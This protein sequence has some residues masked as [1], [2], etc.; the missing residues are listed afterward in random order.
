MSENSITENEAFSWKNHKAILVAAICFFIFFLGTIAIN[1][2]TSGLVDGNTLNVSGNETSQ[3]LWF[4]QLAGFALIFLCFVFILFSFATQL[5]SL[6]HAF[7]DLNDKN[8][9]ILRTVHEGFFSLTSD[10]KIGDQIS[11]SA[12]ELFGQNFRHGDDFFS[13]IS[14]SVSDKTLKET[15]EFISL[16]SAKHVKEQ[17]IQ[18]INP[19]SKIEVN[20]KNKLGTNKK[21]YLMLNFSRVLDQKGKLRYLLVTVQDITEKLELEEKVQNERQRSQ[22]E[23]SMLVKAME[24]DPEELHSFVENAEERLLYVNDLLR[25][26]SSINDE[27][28]LRSIIDEILR[29]IHGIKGNAAALNL[30]SITGI[31]H[32]FENEL[33]SIKNSK[34][35]KI[36]LSEEL[37]SL[38][39]PLGNLL[40]GISMLK[41]IVAQGG[42]IS[43]RTVEIDSSSG[44][45][46]TTEQL[47]EQE[48][49]ATDDSIINP[50]DR[51]ILTHLI[52]DISKE[53]GNQVQLHINCDDGWQKFSNTTS[54]TL[55][56]IGIQ[57]VRNAIVHGI[58]PEKDRVT[59]KKGKVGNITIDL[60]KTD[61]KTWRLSV[62]DDGKGLYAPT[63]RK[64]LKALKWYT[65]EKLNKLS[66]KQVIM[67]IFK[68]GFS[69]ASKTS[70][71]AGRGAGLDLIMHDMRKLSS[72]HLHISST[73]GEFTEFVLT[74]LND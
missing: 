66:D 48:S 71:H 13:L 8:Q 49:P 63:I 9:D 72:A 24:A 65:D 37:L 40:A 2:Y 18:S 29:E 68:P 26:T 70:I 46:A 52:K 34:A 35:R 32:Q 42:G 64:K 54:Q 17:L 51:N 10:F 11:A 55:R 14:L 36:D 50:F 4:V 23:F 19:L 22:N 27:N 44:G 30:D 43:S 56:E 33:S 73:P 53:H 39:I 74:F 31:A 58:E 25:S 62:K 60:K 7:A 41:G 38:P 3:Q 12:R 5:R 28:R 69:T 20:L 45:F 21:H 57:L 16:L 47:P 1:I 15:R 6:S 61:P 67:H 59:A